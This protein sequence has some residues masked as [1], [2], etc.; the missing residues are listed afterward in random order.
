MQEKPIRRLAHFLRSSFIDGVE[1]AIEDGRA[2]I[3]LHVVMERGAQ[4]RP[5][6]GQPA[7][8]G[9]LPGR[10]GGRRAARRG[11]RARR[12]PP[13]L[14]V[15]LAAIA[16]I[17]AALAAI[18]AERGV[19]NDLNVYPVPDGD[20]GT[21]LALTVRAVLDELQQSDAE[22]VPDVAAAVTKGSLMG[23]RGNS[24]VILSQIVRGLC[25][26]WGRSENLSTAGFK[27]AL[28][29]GTSCAYRAVKEPVEGTMLTVIREMAGRGAERARRRGASTSCS[30]PS[31]R[32]G[33]WRSRRPP[34]SSPPSRRPASSTPAGTACWCSSAA[35]PSAS[36]SSCRASVAV[37]RARSRCA[38]ARARAPVAD[39]HASRPS[40]PRTATAPASSSRASASTR[41]PSRRSCCPSATAPSWSGDERMVK[42]H[43][44]TN[45]PGVV[46][47]A[48]AHAW[49]PS[50]RSRSTTCTSRPA[51]ATSACRTGRLP[52]RPAPSW[53]PW[54]PARA[55]RRSSA[56][57]AAPPSSTAASP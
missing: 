40:S 8:A 49:A 22:T 26:V 53:W 38:A 2:N 35:S 17:D 44:H 52:L 32:P 33:G 21:N 41:R 50:A 3:A 18:E 20:T 45:D 23:A 12:G 24:G 15:R 56:S 34:T 43:V 9:A 13:G 42:V 48:G 25:E 4:P 29:E 28:A 6:H 36:S 55:T 54:S 7:G 47:T 51:P 16:V 30:S 10:R 39:R 37:S 5:G 14:N 19:I 57:S 31:R 27:A 46:L 1:V 11:H